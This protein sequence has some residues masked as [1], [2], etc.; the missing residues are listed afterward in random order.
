MTPGFCV[1]FAFPIS[2]IIFGWVTSQ[3]MPVLR[4]KKDMSEGS[5]YFNAIKMPKT[6]HKPR[7]SYNS[8]GFNLV[9]IIKCLDSIL[10]NGQDGRVEHTCRCDLVPS[11]LAKNQNISSWSSALDQISKIEE[12]IQGYSQEIRLKLQCSPRILLSN[13]KEHN[14]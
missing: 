1:L 12:G 10:Q 3:F 11:L 14:F 9:Q 4:K 8:W 5:C 7:S 6:A 2:C 13:M